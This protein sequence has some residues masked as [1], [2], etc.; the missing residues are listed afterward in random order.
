MKNRRS[1]ADLRNLVRKILKI[2]ITDASWIKTKTTQITYKY[3]K[4]K[5]IFD[6]LSEV[7]L[8]LFKEQGR[9]QND[10]IKNQKD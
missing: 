10:G 4:N 2:K 7:F 6:F 3:N 9:I 1:Q 8:R 5:D